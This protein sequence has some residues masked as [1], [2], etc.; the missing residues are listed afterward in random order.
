MIRTVAEISEDSGIPES[1]ITRAIQSRELDA[2]KSETGGATIQ[3]TPALHKWISENH[4][5]RIYASLSGDPEVPSDD[6]MQLLAKLPYLARRLVEADYAALTLGNQQGRIADMIVSGMSEAQS[7]P[8]AHPPI[9]KGVLGNLDHAEAPLRLGDIASHQRSTGFP[10]G[11][12]DMKAMIGVGV[13]SDKNQDETIRIY[14]TRSAGRLPFTAEDQQLIESL[15]SF[16]KQALDFDS[17]RKAETQLR[18]R[19]ENAEK[20]KSDFMSMINHDLRN[21]MAAIQAAIEMVNIDENYSQAQL[22]EDIKSSLEVQSA[23]IGSL[24]DMARLGKTEQDYDFENYY[25]V[26]LINAV[27]R[28]QK[29]SQRAVGRAIESEVAES[30]PA[31]RCDPVQMGR[32]FDN[33]VT[34]ALKYS[35]GK[36]RITTQHNLNAENIMFQVI[37]SGKGIP[38]SEVQRIFK[39][40]ERII[41]TGNP[42]E[43]LGLGLTICKTI[44][45]AHFGTITYRRIDKKKG[46]SIFEVTLPVAN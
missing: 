3:E 34:N 40:F 37:D 21:P 4:P 9:G 32:V 10:E 6:R 25:P 24:L 18:I 8:I 12:P 17:I 20:A 28:R 2:L 33:L 43:G 19:A 16:A 26:D 38:D 30:L 1:V 36:V 31:I 22:V 45:E 11:H 27:I 14:V 7:E 44:V 41:K 13:S 39:P 5:A 15:A 35:D 23:L 46:G 42:I 29:K